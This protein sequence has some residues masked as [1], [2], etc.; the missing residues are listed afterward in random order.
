MNGVAIIG[1]A[2][3][4]VRLAQGEPGLTMKPKRKTLMGRW[5]L[6]GGSWDCHP[7]IIGADHAPGRQPLSGAG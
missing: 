5:L 6:R 3:T 7:F 1:K 4:S 2:N